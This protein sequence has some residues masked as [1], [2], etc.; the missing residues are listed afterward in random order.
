MIKNITYC[1]LRY[2][3]L[4]LSLSDFYIAFSLNALVQSFSFLASWFSDSYKLLVILVDQLNIVWK[5]IHVWCKRWSLSSF[6]MIFK[7]LVLWLILRSQHIWH[8]FLFESNVLLFVSRFF[9]SRHMLWF[10]AWFIQYIG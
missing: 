1:F 4:L 8:S 5:S 2:T 10:D 7:F 9:L 3:F 6:N